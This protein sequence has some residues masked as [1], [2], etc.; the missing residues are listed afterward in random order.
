MDD[1]IPRTNASSFGKLELALEVRYHRRL[2]I[3]QQAELLLTGEY[4]ELRFT[5]GS[6]LARRVTGIACSS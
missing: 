3:R 1:T 2:Q 5:R 4:E 6:P